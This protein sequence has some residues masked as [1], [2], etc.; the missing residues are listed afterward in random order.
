M[1]EPTYVG[2]SVRTQNMTEKAHSKW[3]NHFQFEPRMGENENILS[4]FYGFS[5]EKFYVSSRRVLSSD[6]SLEEKPSLP[7]YPLFCNTT[8]ETDK[9]RG[10]DANMYAN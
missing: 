10:R 6:T 4:P 9:R 5:G 3:R 2:G 7:E 8:L 1:G